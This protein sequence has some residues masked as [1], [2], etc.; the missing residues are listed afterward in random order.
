MGIISNV[1]G[2]LSGKYS[3]ES[4]KIYKAF[5]VEPALDELDKQCTKEWSDIYYG[6][7]YWLA[8]SGR[9]A[10]DELF[11]ADS[12]SELRTL[13]IGKTVCEELSRLITLDIDIQITG[14]EHAKY[15]QKIVDALKKT[16]RGDIELACGIGYIVYKASDSGADVLTPFD[17]IPIRYVKKELLEAIFIDKVERNGDIYVRAEYH[18][19][20]DENRYIIKNKA[21]MAIDKSI[22]MQEVPL[23]TI[24]EWKDIREEVNIPGLEHPLFSV[25]AVPITNNISLNSKIPMSCYAGCI[26][27]LEDID[28]AYTIFADE[29]RT[30]GKMIFI[31]KFA[32]ENA[33]VGS[34]RTILPKFV[35]GLDFGVTA[36]NTIHEYNPVIQVGN[37]RE[38]INLLLSFIGN[39]C[40]FSEGHFM[41]NEKT[42]LLTATEV[43]ADQRRTINTI[44]TYR[45][46][47]RDSIDRL[48]E[49]I[50][51][52]ANMYGISKA[53][54][55]EVHYYFKDI[56]ANF[57][58]DRRR[59]LDL[60][61]ANILP[62]WMYLM[63]FEG[64]TEEE[65]K[66]LVK[67]ANE[68]GGSQRQDD[69]GNQ[70]DQ[71]KEQYQKGN[72]TVYAETE[73]T[74]KGIRE[75]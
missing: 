56:T 54:N 75:V 5:G 38:Q 48:I 20:I 39:K 58:E 62:K 14:S 49:C 21:F 52:Y 47:L 69:Y 27:Q 9:T 37:H 50:S 3:I 25:F 60:V 29:T 68:D 59:N 67:E 66:E 51:E 4:D 57:E 1:I 15:L 61:R 41:F 45:T 28:I 53:D 71:L 12:N 22:A 40:G 10:T 26:D 31:S 74:D 55:Y 63:K 65:A 11:G 36:E 43:E 7:A 8:R 70:M 46:A 34:Q 72:K 33:S 32:L 42:G 13:D 24:E 18:N 16:L 35:K 19:Y 64:Y 23:S 2:Y 44:S 30:S 6:N 73:E 17:V